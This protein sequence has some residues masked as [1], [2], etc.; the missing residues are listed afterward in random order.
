LSRQ[1]LLQENQKQEDKII[2]QRRSL[3]VTLMGIIH[4]PG[5]ASNFHG[6]IKNKQIEMKSL[7][8]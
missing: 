5:N 4:L 1:R 6:K 2:S 7:M 8:S 3:K